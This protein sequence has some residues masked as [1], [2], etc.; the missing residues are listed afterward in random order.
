MR[1]L[2]FFVCICRCL[3][4]DTFT[5]SGNPA[6]LIINTA[7]AGSQPNSVQ[8]ASTS[9]SISTTSNRIITGKINTAMASGLTLSVSL[10]A[11]AGATSAGLQSM[12]T[13]AKNL[14]TGIPTLSLTMGLTIT[15]RLA[16]VTAAPVTNQTR[17]LT[18]TL[19]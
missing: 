18:L 4:A 13:T 2:L 8:N 1:W 11:P 12:T 17:T 6:T 10:A 14:V 5:V 16:T 9:Y 3:L 19:Q 7:T 15:Y